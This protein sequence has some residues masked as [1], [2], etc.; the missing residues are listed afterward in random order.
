[1]N[2][3]ERFFGLREHG[4]TVGTEVRAGLATFLTMAY[5]LAVNPQ[6]LSAAG[7]PA[8]DV[9]VATAIGAAL[10]TLLMGLW[11]NYP[12]ALAPGMGLNAYFA[13]GVVLGMGISWQVALAAVFV[14]GLIFIGL[15]FGGIRTALIKAF[16]ASIRL[17]TAGGI[18]LFLALIG[19]KSAGLVV[20]NPATLVALGDL[21]A[22]TVLLSLLGLVGIA[23][24]V[25][26]KVK[27][28]ILIGI[29]AITVLAWVLGLAPAPEGFFSMPSLPTTT[30]MAFDFSKVLT[31]EF[32]T[33]V[34]AFL[35]VDIFD[36]AGTLL[37]VSR[38]GGLLTP[39][40]ELPRANKAFAAD[41]LGT[42]VGAVFG[43]STVTSYVESAAGVEE[44]GRTGLTAVTVA[45]LFLLALFLVPVIVAVPAIATAPAL[46]VVGAMM[47][48]SVK[49]LDWKSMDE[50][51]P[52]FL[53]I[54]M[55][56][57]TYSIANGIVF[58][59][60][61]YVL[62]KALSGKTKDLNP[63][64]VIVAAVLAVYFGFLR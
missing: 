29:A 57:F 28:A 21:H 6:I 3:I 13:F 58:G 1:V 30:F 44:G 64:L 41:A 26:A 33:V 43:T 18:G 27:G 62:V 51:I 36:T 56:P 63:I 46:I 16:P 17:A 31:P 15:S 12:V 2:R 8:A 22:P 55:M 4:T 19:L 40:G 34:F 14:E 38:L 49:D 54:A 25:A 23:V 59:L 39:E 42:S 32:V 37:G 50:A 11:A 60:V 5:I 48:G 20:D 9:T 53:T 45:V 35:F 10:A 47:I 52:A 24:M 61:S 7:M